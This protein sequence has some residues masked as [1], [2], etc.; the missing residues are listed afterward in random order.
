MKFEQAP[1]RKVVSPEGLD[2]VEN[3]EKYIIALYH[4][5]DQ[6]NLV[7]DFNKGVWLST[8]PDFVDAAN[9]KTYSGKYVKIFL[10]IKNAKLIESYKLMGQRD[11]AKDKVKWLRE[12]GYD[13]VFDDRFGNKEIQ[14]YFIVNQDVVASTQ[15]DAE[16]LEEI[17]RKKV[18]K[19]RLLKN[20]W[21]SV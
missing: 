3:N 17:D 14:H 18:S 16:A 15:E 8:R 4:H 19:K 10:N 5:T 21:H 12:N 7:L 2:S 6:E 20:W 13:G 1:N 11:Y 9:Q